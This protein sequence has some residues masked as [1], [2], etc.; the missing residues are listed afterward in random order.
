MGEVSYAWDSINN[1][2]IH[3]RGLMEISWN[4]SHFPEEIFSECVVWVAW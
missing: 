1:T 3:V 2:W 4:D